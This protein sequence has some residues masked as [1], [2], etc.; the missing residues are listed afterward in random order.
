MGVRLF[1]E[2]RSDRGDKYK[3]EIHDTQFVA[4]STEFKVDSR[5]FELTYDGET[6]DIVSPIVGS[7]L[8]FGAYS[9]DGTFE[10]FIA[11]L[12]TFQETIHRNPIS[13]I[14]RTLCGTKWKKKKEILFS[15]AK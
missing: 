7:K 13:K 8:T 4:A 14:L 10:T 9:T 2:F 6:D 11:L 5:G 3:I 12:K 1:S 15:M